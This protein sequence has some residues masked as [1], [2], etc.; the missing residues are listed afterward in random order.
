MLYFL[1]LPLFGL[2]VAVARALRCGCFRP[3]RILRPC[4]P[5]PAAPDEPASGDV[6]R[7]GLKLK[8]L[9][10]AADA[11]VV[12]AGASGLA[13]AALLARSGYRVLVLEQHDR[14]GGGLH[15]FTEKGAFEW[16]TG[17]HYS[18]ELRPGEP[19]RAIVDALT[20]GEVEF[21]VLDAGPL[22][23]GNYDEVRFASDGPSATPFRV[24]AGKQQWIAALKAAF[25]HEHP[26]I[27]QYVADMH[28]CS[29]QGLTYQIWRSFPRGSCL[30]RLTYRLLASKLVSYQRPAATRLDELTDN[31]RLKA[32]LG[33]ISLGCCAVLPHE[34]QY[35]AM[36]GLHAHFT[37]GAMYPVGGPAQIAKA[38]V[39]QIERHGGRV[40]VRA[41][42]DRI[43]VDRS[44]GQVTGVQLVKAQRVV[45][46]PVV[47]SSVG[48]RATVK[49]LL[50]KPGDAGPSAKS[51]CFSGV[52]ASEAT[53][54]VFADPMP[55]AARAALERKVAALPYGK[56]HIYGFVGLEGSA[57]QL[58]LPRRN[59]WTFPSPDLK[60]D[61]AKFQA[62]PT[63][64]F[65]YVGLAFPSAKDPQAAVKFPGNSTGA[66]VCGDVPWSWFAEWAE[67]R[68]HKRGPEYE[69]FKQSFEARMH[70]VLY[71]NYP[72]CRGKVRHFELG[73]PLDTNY[74]LGRLTGASYGIPP[75]PAK[76][77]ADVD[78]LRPEI[79]EMPEGMFV[80]GQ[81]VTV[82]GFAP[83][84]LSA[85]M[86]MAAIEGPL[87][88]LEVVPMLGGWRK[89]L[90]VL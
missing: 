59:V 75:T 17:F 66:F 11:V 48:L 34:I 6:L 19:L 89:T 14:A 38:L 85:L 29:S 86:A 25:P 26:A 63:E 71:A 39:R 32:L 1:L 28:D 58:G 45:Q 52:A 51:S 16:D 67:S 40:L 65:G 53:A 43:L 8:E 83:A 46:A 18:G 42:V 78:W 21:S 62:D 84:C 22:D 13:C 5:F 50:R 49:G 15:T 33:Y 36:L 55:E 54:A 10:A 4:A 12:G 69:R 56:G 81:D 68:V 9:P 87:H 88:W 27:D 37:N 76:G 57:E 64:P 80:C 23:N 61:M 73:T 31:L 60:G 77:R 20:G 79:D 24:P 74:Y 70:E 90:E 44:S 35:S 82:D 2:C 30:S 41:A 3:R 47:V 7:R 72:K